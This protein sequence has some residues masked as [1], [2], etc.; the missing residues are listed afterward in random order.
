M[1][2]SSLYTMLKVSKTTFIKKTIRIWLRNAD[3]Q[4]R[5]GYTDS[6]YSFIHPPSPPPSRD[7][8]PDPPDIALQYRHD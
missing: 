5:N 3:R 1:F 6:F 4:I 8:I 2:S 7:N